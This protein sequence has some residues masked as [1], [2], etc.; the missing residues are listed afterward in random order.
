MLQ[1]IRTCNPNDKVVI[2]SNFTSALS[3]IESSILEPR[4]FSYLRLDGN[5]AAQNR[6]SL[7]DTFNRTTTEHSFCFLLSAKAGGC[8]LNL[9][10]AN[11]LVMFDNDWNPST[12]IQSMGRVYRTGQTK[13]CFIYRLFT[14]GTLEEV[15]FQRQRQKAALSELTVDGEGKQNSKASSV[16][17]FSKEELKDCFTLKAC[18]C[19]TKWKLGKR[20]PE[21]TGADRLRELGCC[22]QPLLNV[23]GTMDHIVTFIHI[24]NDDE[25]LSI[26][27]DSDVD[28]NCDKTS[29]KTTFSD[30][31]SESENEFVF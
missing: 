6:Q 31:S 14:S 16:T 7:V 28:M 20:W 30:E 9:I 2:V 26:C 15:I 19:D 5:T 21:Y 24:S 29:E 27:A 1:Q 3:I 12:D 25:A 18:A 22:D 10:G 23:A 17:K 11:R 4:Q 13:P 8:G